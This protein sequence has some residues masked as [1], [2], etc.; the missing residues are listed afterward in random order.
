MRLPALTGLRFLMALWVFLHHAERTSFGVA[1]RVPVVRTIA[2]TGYLG[3]GFFFVLSGFILTITSAETLSWRTY[4]IRRAARIY[5]LYLLVIV[6]GVLVD[7]ISGYSVRPLALIAGVFVAQAWINIPDVYSVGVVAGWSLSVEAFLY[8]IF[9]AVARRVHE[10]SIRRWTVAALLL[11]VGGGSLVAL[12]GAA[13][14]YWAYVFPLSR[15]AEFVLGIVAARWYMA[16]GRISPR[17]SKPAWLA[18]SGLV[19]T[20]AYLPEWLTRA[21][22][23]AALWP[24]LVL[25][26]AGGA[27]ESSMLASPTMVRLGEASYAFYL[28][29]GLV[30]TM[31]FKVLKLIGN[32]AVAPT[33]LVSLASLVGA[34]LVS[35]V[36]SIALMAFVERPAQRWLRNRYEGDAAMTVGS[37]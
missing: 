14:I 6:A 16:G 32:K 15:V 20:I 13:P 36:T 19:A 34:V 7:Q 17:L 18:L 1:L 35:I 2:S 10:S 9:P 28:V 3:V 11:A 25:V 31:T 30:L 29:H 27:R 23:L 22:L 21:A 8:V 33:T 12:S 24:V 26:V 37:A 5:P 4:L